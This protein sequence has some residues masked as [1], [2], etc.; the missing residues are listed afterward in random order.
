M[1]DI[2]II[3]RVQQVRFGQI[4]RKLGITS[5]GTS[6]STKKS[7]V[8]TPAK[9]KKAPA[10]RAGSKGKKGGKVKKEEVVEDDGYDDQDVKEELHQDQPL[11]SSPGRDDFNVEAQLQADLNAMVNPDGFF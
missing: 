10:A 4:K 3:L 7:P 6:A 1:T 11:L 2:S 8:K 9:V 5:D